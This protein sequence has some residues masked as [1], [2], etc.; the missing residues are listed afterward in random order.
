[1][2]FYI[3]G[4]RDGEMM[5]TNK[6]DILSIGKWAEPEFTG[7][8]LPVNKVNSSQI[9]QFYKEAINRYGL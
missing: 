1:H 5:H 6:F 2:Y 4:Y 7:A 9:M 3:S 8:I